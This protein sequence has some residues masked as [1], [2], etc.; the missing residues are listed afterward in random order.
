MQ[1]GR[2]LRR[3]EL[4]QAQVRDGMSAHGDLRRLQPQE[5]Q[6]RLRPVSPQTALLRSHT[7]LRWIQG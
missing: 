1:H 5:R 4:E 6:Q 7:R 2:T 3:K